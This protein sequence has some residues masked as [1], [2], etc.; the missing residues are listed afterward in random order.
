M[1]ENRDPEKREHEKH[2]RS[3]LHSHR[4][5]LRDNLESIAIALVL[6]LVVRQVVV[7][8]FKI[9][10]GSMA[11]TLLGVHKEVRCENCGW[12]FRVGEEAGRQADSVRCPNCWAEVEDVSYYYY[13]ENSRC[14]DRLT[15]KSP[16]WLWHRGYSAR[17]DAEVTGTDAANR[18]NR[19]GSRIFVNKFIYSL[20]EPHRWEVV[21]FRYPFSRDA[22]CHDCG[23]RGKVDDAENLTCPICGSEDVS[24]EARDFI[25]RCIGLPNEELH[26]E[27]GDVYVDGQIARKPP[28]IQERMWMH[29]F[30]SRFMPRREATRVWDYRGRDQLWR[31][32]NLE[33]SLELR[34]LGA[35]RPV[36]A[37][38]G[39]RIV[40]GY[41]YNASPD[42][43]LSSEKHEV[44]DCRICTR[45]KPLERRRSGEAS[46]VLR[47]AEGGDQFTLS[48]PVGGGGD[49]VLKHG[50]GVIKKVPV[51]P[52][53]PGQTVRVALENYDDRVVAKLRGETII[54]HEYRGGSRLYAG[55]NSVQFGGFGSRLL[56]RRVLIQ[57][58]IHYFDRNE[59]GRAPRIYDLGPDQYFML[60]DN[61]PHSSD[62]RYWNSPE[63]FVPERNIIG[64]AFF[65]FW[66]IHE[67]RLLSLSSDD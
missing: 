34:A 24:L 61:C 25:K 64:E 13:G 28:D 56:F 47:I 45:V 15:F 52:L 37:A 49:A 16:A 33:G 55:R 58:D 26:L 59:F 12:V 7:E 30:D 35:D 51:R 42:A 10:T 66:P 41:A 6:V 38:F 57:R 27:G 8:A 63:P 17:C 29:V 53:Q 31:P 36:M 21:V 19:G 39:R 43:P 54:T 11:P 14:S 2:R 3:R 46:V 62:S 60:G 44:G 1:T 9:P 5:P 23:W 67:F 65:V 22:E 18:I 32:G 20:R 40:D 4:T 50:T 48:L